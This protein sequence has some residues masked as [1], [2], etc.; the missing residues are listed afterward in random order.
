MHWRLIDSGVTRTAYTMAVDDSLLHSHGDGSGI[1]TLHIYQRDPPAVSLGYFQNALEEVDL[2][3]CSEH[4]IDVCRRLSGGGTIFCDK[5]QL[6]FSLVLDESIFG[7]I[8]DSFPRVASVISRVVDGLGVSAT[9]SPPNDVIVNGKKIS[10]NAQRRYKGTLLHH[11]TLLLDTDLDSMFNALRVSRDRMASKGLTSPRE[12]VA[13]LRD[14]LGAPPS[15]D[16]VK[17]ALYSEFS[18][19]FRVLIEEGELT[20]SEMELVKRLESE[21]Y[22]NP[23]WSLSR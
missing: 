15:V 1:D 16:D 4:G 12:R 18:N 23:H 2:S 22:G 13:S 20:P 11:S 19:E 6:I 8:E 10:G 14:F 3:Y 21:R 7:S 9:F 5:G 17:K